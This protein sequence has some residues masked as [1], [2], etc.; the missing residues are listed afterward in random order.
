MD[1]KTDREERPG[2]AAQVAVYAR[3][4]EAALGLE[5]RPRCE[6]WYLRLDRAVVA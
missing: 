5:R 3:A 2:Y 4:L 1:Y 6:L